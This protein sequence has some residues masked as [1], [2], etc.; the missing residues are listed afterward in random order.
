MGSKSGSSIVSFYQDLLP[1][2]L[3]GCPVGVTDEKG[4]RVL[5]VYDTKQR[6]Q[7]HSLLRPVKRPICVSRVKKW[8]SCRRQECNLR[9]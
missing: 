2:F 5:T 7:A 3:V 4:V 8:A 9:R 1:R 6:H